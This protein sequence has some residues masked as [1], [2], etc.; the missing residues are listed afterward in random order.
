MN[1]TITFPS[2]R[3]LIHR[4]L[5]CDC[6]FF[7]IVKCAGNDI[8]KMIIT[9]P[10]ARWLIYLTLWNMSANYISKMTITFPRV[11]WLIHRTLGNV[12]VI[13]EIYFQT[14]CGLFKLDLSRCRVVLAALCGVEPSPPWQPGHPGIPTLPACAISPACRRH[15]PQRSLQPGSCRNPAPLRQPSRGFRGGTACVSACLRIK[16]GLC[17]QANRKL[18]CLVQP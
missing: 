17:T 8:S 1:Y 4:S 11:R 9:F 10:R 18:S 7:N 12:I 6:H 5:G 13:L 14:H 16:A 2:V 15:W 3:W